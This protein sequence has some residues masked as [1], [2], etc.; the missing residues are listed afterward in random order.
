MEN[1]DGSLQ[2]ILSQMKSLNNFNQNILRMAE[3]SQ[4]GE[5]SQS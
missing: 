2:A 3:S 4:G 1:M 5:V